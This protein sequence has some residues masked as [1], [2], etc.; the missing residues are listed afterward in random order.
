MSGHFSRLAYD[1]CFV[2]E[3][4]KQSTAPGDY[5][6]YNGQVNNDNSCHSVF[7]PR[8]NRAHSSTEVDKGVTQGDRAEIESVLTNRDEPAS[9]CSGNRKLD[10]KRQKLA[11]E[12]QKSVYCGN[13]LNPTNSRLEVPIDE[14]RGLSTLPLQISYPLINPTENVFN[15]H[16]T[17]SL[18][19]Q[20][21]N[22]RNGTN[23]RLEA[24][25]KYAAKF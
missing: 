22:S 21:I 2:N 12:L 20:D 7:G 16:N 17:S 24:K 15:G 10:N 25:D 8:N 11:N 18:S 13:F 14:Y 19:N 9:R 3:E 1:Q 5:T 6:L 23:T 4:I